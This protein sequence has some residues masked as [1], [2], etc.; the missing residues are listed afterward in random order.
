MALFGTRTVNGQVS[1]LIFI[2]NIFNKFNV[3]I[4]NTYEFQGEYFDGRKLKSTGHVYLVSKNPNL[5]HPWYRTGNFIQFLPWPCISFFPLTTPSALINIVSFDLRTPH[6]SEFNM[7]SILTENVHEIYM[8]YRSLYIL[9]KD[10]IGGADYTRINKVFVNGLGIW[11]LYERRIRGTYNNQFSFDEYSNTGILRVATTK[12]NGVFQTS[13]SVYTLSFTLNII[14]QRHNIYP[15]TS[16]T[17]TR[18]DR[19]RLYIGISSGHFFIVHF[20]PSH[21][22]I[23]VYNPVHLN[24][25]SKHMQLL[26]QN[27]LLN[28]GKNP[29]G[30]GLKMWV[31]YVA[32][33]GF[34]QLV[35]QPF[36]LD[37]PGDFLAGSIA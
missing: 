31:Y 3:V 22:S 18:F 16:I 8:S 11:P 28:F 36:A 33:I 17:V 19:R 13:I 1:T 32:N 35:G 25:E 37:S 29:N 20:F 23:V 27:Y 9:Y 12:Y 10:F 26:T 5:F 4:V 34:P 7:K 15:T 2:I 21:F 6:P 24:G 14:Q 30:G